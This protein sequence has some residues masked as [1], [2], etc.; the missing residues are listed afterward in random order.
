MTKLTINADCGNAP[1]KL[2]LRDLNIAFARADVEAILEIFSDD[3]HWRIIGE[4]NL[5]GKETV[6]AALEAMKDTVTTELTIHSIITH[7]P[8]AA[9]NGI[10]TTEQSG[11]F[12]FCDVYR[13]TSASGKKINAMTSY[14]ID[15]NAGE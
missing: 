3:I 9:V 11:T 6:R 1:K 13:F 15:L 7:G 14:V 5:R 2:I 12:A 10:I 8:E 4:A